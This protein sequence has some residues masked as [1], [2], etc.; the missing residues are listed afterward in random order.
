MVA[1]GRGTGSE[2]AGRRY[3]DLGAWVCTCVQIH[4]AGP[5]KCA[6][7]HVLYLSSVCEENDKA[8]YMSPWKDI[9]DRLLIWGRGGEARYRTHSILPVLGEREKKHA[10]LCVHKEILEGERRN[11][12]R[13]Q[14][15]Q[16][17]SSIGDR[18]LKGGVQGGIRTFT[19]TFWTGEC[20]FYSKSDL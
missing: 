4:Q 13:A 7:Q 16:R 2:D 5:L 18:A 12:G 1:L 15:K 8:L 17:G 6:S 9:Q 10:Y 19:L 11:P 20:S 14:R 3:L